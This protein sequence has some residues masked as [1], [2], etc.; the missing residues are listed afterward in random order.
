M[1]PRLAHRVVFPTPPASEY[2]A[3]AVEEAPFGGAIATSGQAVFSCAGAATGASAA[4]GRTGLFTG[5]LECSLRRRAKLWYAGSS[6][7]AHEYNRATSRASS[8][9]TS[10]TSPSLFS[11]CRF[12]ILFYTPVLRPLALSYG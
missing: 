3:I 8:W 2:T 7:F 1:R 9:S 5:G 12:D 4:R 6:T 10:T 11:C